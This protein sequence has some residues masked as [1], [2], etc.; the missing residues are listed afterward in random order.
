[1]DMK[2]I[3][4]T[5]GVAE[6]P[7]NFEKIYAQIAND[8]APACDIALIEWAQKEFEAF[9][10]HYD[11]VLEGAKQINEDP[12]YSAW[13]KVVHTYLADPKWGSFKDIKVPPLNG[14]PK[15]DMAMLMAYVPF[16][17]SAVEKYKKG[18]FAHADIAHYIQGFGNCLSST[19]T[20]TG[21]VGLDTVYFRWLKLF[22][23]A[24]IFT[25]HGI[26]FQFTKLK[27]DAMFLRNKQTGQVVPV[28]AAGLIHA[29]G[30]H[31]VGAFGFEDAE[32]AVEAVITET[33]ES[34]T[35][36]GVFD[37][38]ISTKLQEF[39]K[40]QWECIGRPGDKCIAL[41]LPR[42]CD[43]T[44]ENIQRAR[45]A[46]QEVIDRAYPE[47]QNVQYQ[48]ASWL[49]DA[50]LE[51]ILGPD[52]NIVRFGK[53]FARYPGKSPGRAANSFVFPGKP[54]AE[55]DLPENSRLQRG[56]KQLYLNGGGTYAD[57]GILI[58]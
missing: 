32:G 47:Y 5:L 22:A 26:Q 48:C 31:L 41:H 28:M 33:E 14:T 36:Y 3:A 20:R 16:I 27:P 25:V 44:K 17:P 51:A 10:K 52:S 35:G 4:Q 13:V 30:K 7:E 11:L 6:Y 23:W 38:V 50:G 21:F 2:Q 24:E 39:R 58:L 29:T 12:I 8:T 1:M 55:K 37:S 15:Q 57:S 45:K 9:K 40:D 42:G 18:G 49:L 53:L 43:I 46:A 56:I 54:V 34:F 19:S